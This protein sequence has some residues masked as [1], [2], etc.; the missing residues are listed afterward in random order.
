M[1]TKRQHFLN[2]A[3]PGD[4]NIKKV[5]EIVEIKKY[6]KVQIGVTRTE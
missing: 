2:V 6:T 5:M 1:L 3:V 4:H